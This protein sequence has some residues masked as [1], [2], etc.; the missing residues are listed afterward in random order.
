VN[1]R[2]EQIT[3]ILA[4][5]LFSMALTSALMI[6][7]GERITT[8]VDVGGPGLFF[9]LVFGFLCAMFGRDSGGEAAGGR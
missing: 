4:I 3:R 7:N 2:E 6:E 1:R 8:L 9:L 5:A